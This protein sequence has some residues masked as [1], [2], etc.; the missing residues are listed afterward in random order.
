MTRIATISEFLLEAG[1][2]YRIIDMGRGFNLVDN[3]L[4]LDIENGSV[5][6]PRPRQQMLW[7]GILFWN[8]SLSSQHYIWFIKLPLDEQGKVIAAQ[9][10][11][12]LQIVIEALGTELLQD[13]SEKSLPDNP[14]LFTPNQSQLADF[15]SQARVL[16]GLKPGQ[17]YSD[18]K[19][20]IARPDIND[21]QNVALQGLSD[22]VFNLNL[23]HNEQHIIA[24]FEQY[25]ELV[26]HTLLASLENAPLSVALADFLFTLARQTRPEEKAFIPLLRSLTHYPDQQALADNLQSLLSSRLSTGDHLIVIAGRHWSLSSN[27]AFLTLFME[28]ASRLDLLP[29]LYADLVQIPELREIMLKRLRDPERSE[30]LAT[31][32]NKLF[33]RS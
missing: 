21:W 7:L 2:E 13:D 4:F 6:A 18:A 28:E 11:Q 1:T 26:Q 24:H 20:Y 10:D 31:G 22:V 8:K 30:I 32:I 33:G 3:Q 12:F 15:N 29:A 5:M 16:L 17:Y 19:N 9:R 27:Y 23:D 25:D 14:F